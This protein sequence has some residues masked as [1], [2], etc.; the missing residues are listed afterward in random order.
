M[1][2]LIA[3]LQLF[4][5]ALTKLGFTQH[6]TKVDML[7]SELLMNAQEKLADGS[8]VKPHQ[9]KALLIKAKARVVSLQETLGDL[10][11]YSPALARI[12]YELSQEIDE[13]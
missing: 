7:T 12:A 4:S 9:R 6:A 2:E 10:H 11:P 13:I 5:S 3:D 1:D 8:S